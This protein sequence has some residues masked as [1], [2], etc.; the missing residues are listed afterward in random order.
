[1]VDM[2]SLYL[3]HTTSKAAAALQAISLDSPKKPAKKSAKVNGIRRCPSPDSETETGE[4]EELDPRKRFVGDIDLSE[5]ASILLP[6]FFNLFFL[7]EEPLL[8]ESKRRFVLFPIQYH[9]VPIS[10]NCPLSRG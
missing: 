9:E 8:M 2:C 1:M 7:G 4:Y 10:T 5:S 6:S 3:P